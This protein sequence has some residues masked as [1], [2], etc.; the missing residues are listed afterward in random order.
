VDF[1]T[2]NR[3]RDARLRRRM[4]G[5]LYHVQR[6]PTG[7][8]GGRTLFDVVNGATE[9]EQFESEDH[10]IGLMRE[11]ET[12]G[13]ARSSARSTAGAPAGS[14]WTTSSCG[15]RRTARSCTRRPGRLTRWSRTIGSPARRFD[16]CAATAA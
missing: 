7:W 15:S 12:I 10:A 6:S 5:A 13:F 14:A 8:V 9:A 11:M 1:E 2:A 3:K 16:A 4:L